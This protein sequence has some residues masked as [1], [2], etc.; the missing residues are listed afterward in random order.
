MLSK[1]KSLIAK[2]ILVIRLLP[3]EPR[4]STKLRKLLP[5]LKSKSSKLVTKSM[6]T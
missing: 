3:E 4:L 2:K 5:Q 1:S 6:K